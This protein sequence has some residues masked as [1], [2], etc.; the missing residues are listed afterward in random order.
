MTAALV[1]GVSLECW[2]QAGGRVKENM[3]DT[4]GKL[5]FQKYLIFSIN[6][7]EGSGIDAGHPHMGRHLTVSVSR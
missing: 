5:F 4:E 3:K 6:H 2:G 1:R 7:L